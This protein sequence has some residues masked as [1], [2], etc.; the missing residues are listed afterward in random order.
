VLYYVRKNLNLAFREGETLIVKESLGKATDISFSSL[1]PSTIYSTL[2]S[3]NVW[4]FE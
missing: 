2:Q 1:L 3:F 4:I